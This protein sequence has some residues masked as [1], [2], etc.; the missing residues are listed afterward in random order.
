MLIGNN[1]LCTKGFTINPASASAHILSCGVTIVINA[2]NHLLFL[3]RNV[4]ADA[5]TFIPPK[6][7]A[8]I[9]CQQISLPN[10]RDFLFQPFP[11]QQL[12]LYSHLLDHT[13]LRILVW[14]DTKCLIQI[15][16]RHRLGF[17]TEIPFENYF[18]TLVEHDAASTPP[19]SPLLFYKRNGITIP[20]ADAGLETELSNGIKIYRDSQAVEKIIRLVNEYL[21][22]WKSSGF[23]QVPPKQWMKVHL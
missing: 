5:T 3:R 12:M 23:V 16:R 7:E 2:R 19:M 18:A 15:P 20:P 1:I 17:I 13:S 9:N 21:S 22:I 11:Q 4:L 6:S 10:L 14:N 8:L